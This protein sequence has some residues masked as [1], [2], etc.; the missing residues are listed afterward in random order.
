MLPD[1]QMNFKS[2]TNPISFIIFIFRKL[3]NG[4]QFRN[5][6]QLKSNHLVPPDRAV[7]SD[8]ILT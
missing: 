4:I 2:D 5:S 8:T 7:R 1:D 3:D 6:F